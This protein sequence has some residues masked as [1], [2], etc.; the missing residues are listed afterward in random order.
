MV[1]HHDR[2]AIV[3]NDLRRICGGGYGLTRWNGRSRRLC[4]GLGFNSWSRAFACPLARPSGL[5]RIFRL[6]GLRRRLGDESGVGAARPAFSPP[7][8]A[9][10]E[11]RVFR[12]NRLVCFWLRGN[13]G[14][15]GLPA[16]GLL[17]LR[18]CLDRLRPPHRNPVFFALEV[19]QVQ[20]ALRCRGRGLMIE[21]DLL[22]E[23]CL[24]ICVGNDGWFA[25]RRICFAASW[26]T[27]AFWR[28]LGLDLLH[29]GDLRFKCVGLWDGLGGRL[30]GLGVAPGTGLGFGLFRRH[31]GNR[32]WNGRLNGYWRGRLRAGASCLWRRSVRGDLGRIGVGDVGRR[33]VGG[34]LSSWHGVRQANRPSNPSR[35]QVFRTTRRTASSPTL[36]AR[37]RRRRLLQTRIPLQERNGRH[38]SSRPRKSRLPA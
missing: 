22:Q 4:G 23:R 36:R 29:S 37:R 13:W 14:R 25:R 35:L 9:W 17:P 10:S 1:F 38:A 24:K 12:L 5:R 20:L 3:P 30:A 16:L 15:L 2:H 18:L 32:L 21:I 11:I 28:G 19:L 6:F 33:R 34:F 27:G 26:R 31:L 7:A 8:A